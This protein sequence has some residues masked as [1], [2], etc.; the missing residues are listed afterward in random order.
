MKITAAIQ[1][2]GN[3]AIKERTFTA[4]VKDAAHADRWL[5]GLTEFAERQGHSVIV[6]FIH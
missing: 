2:S 5:R 1:L 4:E 3:H 6:S